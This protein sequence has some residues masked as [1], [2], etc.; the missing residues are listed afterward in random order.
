LVI[1][2]GEGDGG[3]DQ[4]NQRDDT[5]EEDADKGWVDVDALKHVCE[6]V[7]VMTRWH[8]QG[9]CDDIVNQINV[10]ICKRVMCEV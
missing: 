1:D 7:N 10:N 8:K 5:N 4:C 2:L 3:E 6:R 9:A